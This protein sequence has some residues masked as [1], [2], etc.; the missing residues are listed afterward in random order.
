MERLFSVCWYKGNHA[1]Y[2]STI[3]A[4]AWLSVRP[5]TANHDTLG[6]D[7]HRGFAGL[8]ALIASQ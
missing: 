7:H 5:L 8:N 1:H 6:T 2:N 4:L 3:L